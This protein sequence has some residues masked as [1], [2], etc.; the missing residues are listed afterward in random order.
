M[1][2]V[3]RT[4]WCQN[5]K[6][7]LIISKTKQLIVDFGSGRLGIHK[8]VLIDGTVVVRVKNFKFLGMHISGPGTLMPL[9]PWMIEE[10]R[11]VNK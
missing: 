2:V 1:Y 10:I 5:N 6:L 9:L 8:L 11:Y 3:E 7:A 4:V